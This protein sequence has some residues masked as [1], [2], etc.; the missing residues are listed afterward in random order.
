MVEQEE[1]I[2]IL[3][4]SWALLLPQIFD[5]LSSVSNCFSLDS[6]QIILYLFEHIYTGW[7]E[8]EEAKNM[9]GKDGEVIESK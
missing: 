5:S 3:T 9:L 6:G 7:S 1:N 2:Y 8:L 4:W